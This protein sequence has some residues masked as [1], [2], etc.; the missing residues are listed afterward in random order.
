MAII[1]TV[2]S[3]PS[4]VSQPIALSLSSVPVSPIG[5]PAAWFKIEKDS[6]YI[7]I[8]PNRPLPRRSTI[9]PAALFEQ[10]RGFLEVNAV[11]GRLLFANGTDTPQTYRPF[12]HDSQRTLRELFLP[13]EAGPE[14]DWPNSAA[15]WSNFQAVAR[16][17]LATAKI[18]WD[19]LT[20][21]DVA[22]L[23]ELIHWDEPFEGCV[24]HGLTQWSH[25]RGECVIEI[26][27][28]RGRSLTMLAMALRG[29]DSD[30]LLFSVDPHSERPHNRE[31]A[32]LALRHIGE[33]DR[34]VQ[35]SCT[36]DRAARLIGRSTAS[37]IFIDG[38]HSYAQ[39]LADFRNYLDL[40]APGGCLLFHDYGFGNHNGLPEAHPDVRRAIDAEV[41]GHHAL[42]PLL[43]SHTLIAFVK[44]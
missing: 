22:E 31:H 5:Q 18:A 26:G 15:R 2:A 30:A 13:M 7:T 8:R 35:F 32:R 14:D 19:G 10:N 1:E 23:V 11:M 4:A 3:S 29:V 39:V 33:E 6:D 9:R 40:L 24:L 21:R 34:L 42:T 20:P 25:Q 41:F 37:L 28:R 38:E 16:R 17:L 12:T 43:L 27:S 44:K 36:S